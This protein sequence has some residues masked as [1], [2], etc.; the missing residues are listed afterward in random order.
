MLRH[1][2][3]CHRLATVVLRSAASRGW[4]QRR[5]RDPSAANS[6]ASAETAGTTTPG[7]FPGQSIGSQK[8]AAGSTAEAGHE[9]RCAVATEAQRRRAAVVAAG[10]GLFA[11]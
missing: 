2:R 11:P 4:R 7:L 8:D 5:H 6:S 3:S 9:W 10:Q 1:T